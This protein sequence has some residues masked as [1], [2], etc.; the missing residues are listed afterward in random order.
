MSQDD[1][2][3]KLCLQLTVLNLVTLLA[4]MGVLAW[5][6][7]MLKQSASLVVEL[8]ERVRTLESSSR[9]R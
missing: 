8:Q 4:V 9:R 7:I 5:T 3:V 6:L 1:K 2:R